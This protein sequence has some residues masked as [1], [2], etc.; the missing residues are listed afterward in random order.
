MT[1]LV[2]LKIDEGNFEVG[3]KVTVE[4]GEDGKPY[5][6]EFKGRLPSY[7]TIPN[8]YQGWRTNYRLGNKFSL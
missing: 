3:F 2:K 4:I 5:D 6:T 8:D 7:P 1:K